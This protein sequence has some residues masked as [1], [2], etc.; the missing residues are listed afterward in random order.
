[1]CARKH[2]ISS[3]LVLKLRIT[4]VPLIR[5]CTILHSRRAHEQEKN[6]RGIER[7]QHSHTQT[8]LSYTQ[9]ENIVEQRDIAVA[10]Y[11]HDEN[12]KSGVFLCGKRTHTSI[13]TR[14]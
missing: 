11:P 2:L 13:A 4:H 14:R 8:Y 6:V 5:C 7:R 3:D 12:I 1:M 9:F 10:T